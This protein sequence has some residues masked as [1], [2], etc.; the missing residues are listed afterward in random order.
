MA[1][2]NFFTKKFQLNQKSVFREWRNKKTDIKITPSKA[3]I[4]TFCS[5]AWAKSSIHNENAKW[6][7]TFGKNYCKNVTLKAYQINI[8]T[9]KEILTRMKNNGA[10]GPD[11]VNANTIKK[12]SSTNPFLENAFVHTF[13]ITNL[14]QTS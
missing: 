11:K 7:K 8:E 2:R 9:F 4:E 12:L 1:Q 6:L 14:S 5:S 13:E 10:P 3:E